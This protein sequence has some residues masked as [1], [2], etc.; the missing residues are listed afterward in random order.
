MRK[1]K[2]LTV[3]ESLI[4]VAIVLIILAIA[5]GSVAKANTPPTMLS[6]NDAGQ[7]TWKVPVNKLAEFQLAHHDQKTVSLAPITE[8][9]LGE[10]T[11][12]T[13]GYI[14]VLDPPKKVEKEEK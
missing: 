1:Q 6:M 2:G 3:I 7:Q 11:T 5:I 12:K 13:T 8:D 14:I 10:G 4:G 9:T